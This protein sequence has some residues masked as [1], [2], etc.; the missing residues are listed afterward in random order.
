MNNAT[1][2]Q[3]LNDIFDEVFPFGIP[4]MEPA[5]VI[6]LPNGEIG[7]TSPIFDERRVE[8]ENSINAHL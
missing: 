2:E 3:I 6:V 4:L 5:I 8:P 1:Q 7:F